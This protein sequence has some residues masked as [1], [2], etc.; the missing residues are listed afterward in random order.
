MLVQL[1]ENFAYTDQK[2]LL[3]AVR[4]DNQSSNCQ[5]FDKLAKKRAA[6]IRS[7]IGLGPEKKH[8]NSQVIRFL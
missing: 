3:K 4:V 8:R 1:F 2:E 7:F 5:A 6:E